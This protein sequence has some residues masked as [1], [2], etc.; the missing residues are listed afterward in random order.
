MRYDSEYAVY[1]FL[2]GPFLRAS[3]L[4]IGAAAATASLR[5][6][7]VRAGRVTPREIDGAYAVSRL[8]PG[9]NL[10]ALYAVIG[11]DSGDGPWHCPPWRSVSSFR[12]ALH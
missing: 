2:L 4:H 3:T 9:T 5:E 7:L 10:L 12:R 11:I 8:T 1:S 6:E